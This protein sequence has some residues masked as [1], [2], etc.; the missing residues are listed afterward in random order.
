MPILYHDVLEIVRLQP[1]LTET[2]AKF[3]A[4]IEASGDGRFFSPHPFSAE[5]AMR[6]CNYHG[7]DIYLVLKL[8]SDILGYGMLRGWD[9]GY[10]IPSLGIYIHPAVRGSGFGTLLMA[11]L[12]AT[13]R[14][15]GADTVRLRVHRD[16]MIARSLYVQMG[17]E[18]SDDRDYLVGSARVGKENKDRP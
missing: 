6:L 9:E 4:G 11:H 8:G 13:A 16:N 12:H 1:T 15:R 2:V 3:F 18:F 17:Y 14:L 7:K 10:A 5:E